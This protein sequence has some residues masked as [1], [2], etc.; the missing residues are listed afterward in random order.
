[1]RKDRLDLVVDRL[2]FACG[3][4]RPNAAAAQWAGE[5]FDVD[6]AVRVKRRLQVSRLPGLDR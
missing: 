3:P 1:M 6:V 5:H 4:R 2:S